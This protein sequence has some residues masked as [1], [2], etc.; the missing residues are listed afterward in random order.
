MRKTL[1]SVWKI[2]CKIKIFKGEQEAIEKGE[3][4]IAVVTGGSAEFRIGS[5]IKMHRHSRL[6]CQ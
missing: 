1:A 6:L 5:E 4:E 3:N 2:N